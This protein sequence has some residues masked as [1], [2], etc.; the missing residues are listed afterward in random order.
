[1][2][3]SSDFFLGV[4]SSNHGNTLLFNCSVIPALALL[5]SFVVC[6]LYCEAD[7][8]F[9]TRIYKDKYMKDD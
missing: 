1:M 5:G 8:F 4:A 2:T 6:L 3:L 9:P 7:I